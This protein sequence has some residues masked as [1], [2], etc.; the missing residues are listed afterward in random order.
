[1]FNIKPLAPRTSAQAFAKA[2]DDDKRSVAS[3]QSAKALSPAL[4]F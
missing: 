2:F 1:M 4:F 3:G